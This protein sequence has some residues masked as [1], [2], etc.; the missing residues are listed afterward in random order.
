VHLAEASALKGKKKRAKTDWADA[1]HLR[2]LLLIGPAAG[3]VDPAR[4]SARSARQGP[5]PA[6]AVAAVDGMAAADAGGALSPRDSGAYYLQ[7]AE[8][9]GGNRACLALARKLL[10]RC[11]HILTELGDPALEP[12]AN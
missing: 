6:H 2:E 9:I 12:V 7:A 3:V 5:L 10:K 1:R 11:Y 4:A 8:R